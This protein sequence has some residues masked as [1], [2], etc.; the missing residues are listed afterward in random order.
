M[1]TK[2]PTDRWPCLVDKLPSRQDV[3]NAV[4][5]WRCCAYSPS[6]VRESYER[7][8]C[9]F[10]RAF[11]IFLAPTIRRRNRRFGACTRSRSEDSYPTVFTLKRRQTPETCH[12]CDILNFDSHSHSDV[13]QPCYSAVSTTPSRPDSSILE[14]GAISLNRTP[15]G[16][17][18]YEMRCYQA[19]RR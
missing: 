9:T 1:P 13:Q 17:P 4:R 14:R 18:G 6:A 11:S 2:M 12:T 16:P 8:S 3:W 7:D 15:R 19:R 5:S 10:G